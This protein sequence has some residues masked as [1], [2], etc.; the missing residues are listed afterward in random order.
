MFILAE[1][2]TRLE[3]IIIKEVQLKMLQFCV[4]LRMMTRSTL[5]RPLD[6]TVS[7]LSVTDT[8]DFSPCRGVCKPL[9]PIK[10]VGFLWCQLV[11]R[12]RKRSHLPGVMMR[13]KPETEA[14]FGTLP[15][16]DLGFSG[17]SSWWAMRRDA[18]RR[19]D[20]LVPVLLLRSLMRC[21]LETIPSTVRG[22]SGWNGVSH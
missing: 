5:K 1:S 17:V 11:S 16:G 6:D 12:L 15:V 7:K 2:R 4:V 8:L 14:D 19:K 13:D 20:G 21:R 18:P 3:D 9:E 22:N 10:L